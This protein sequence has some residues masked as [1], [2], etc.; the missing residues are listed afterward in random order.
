MEW[1]SIHCQ[2][3][4]VGKSGLKFYDPACK[5]TLVLDFAPSYFPLEHYLSGVYNLLENKIISQIF[6]K[7]LTFS[8]KIYNLRNTVLLMR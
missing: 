6:E 1:G 8:N 4:S 5:Q 2:S 7:I 3:C